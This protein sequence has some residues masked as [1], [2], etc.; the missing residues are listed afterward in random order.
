MGGRIR[1][2]ITASKGESL[3]YYIALWRNLVNFI[4]VCRQNQ[5]L[6]NIYA[7]LLRSILV[8]LIRKKYFAHKIFNN[9]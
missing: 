5:V 7:L 4:N 3:E 9:V 2:I 8:F 1:K 6:L